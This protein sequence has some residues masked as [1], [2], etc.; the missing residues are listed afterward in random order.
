MSDKLLLIL[1]GIFLL[2]F[3]IFAVTNVE[4]VW[5]RAIMGIA[6]LAAGVVCLIRAL[7]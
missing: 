3:G 2:L 7:R 1:L 5:G 4:V 6:A